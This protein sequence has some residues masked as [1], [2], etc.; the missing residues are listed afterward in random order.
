MSGIDIKLELNLSSKKKLT[1]GLRITRY[2][3]DKNIGINLSFLKKSIVFYLGLIFVD[4]FFNIVLSKRG[5][6]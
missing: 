2:T 4:I 5:K 3:P 6:K 1:F